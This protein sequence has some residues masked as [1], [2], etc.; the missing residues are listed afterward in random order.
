MNF[1]LLK[2]FSL[3]FPLFPEYILKDIIMSLNNFYITGI[4]VSN[5]KKII[6]K[7]N[8]NISTTTD[9][10]A[11]RSLIISNINNEEIEER[12]IEQKYNSSLIKNI[13][14]NKNGTKIINIKETSFKGEDQSLCEE[15]IYYEKYYYNKKY[16]LFNI[17]KAK[18]L[19]ENREKNSNFDLLTEPEYFYNAV[20]YVE[21]DKWYVTT[22]DY[23]C[24]IN[25]NEN[26]EKTIEYKS[27]VNELLQLYLELKKENSAD[28]LTI[29]NDKLVNV[30]RRKRTFN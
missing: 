19:F 11:Q 30:K 18:T 5:D 7:I 23:E 16:L 22:S 29:F 14:W 8:I 25:G 17:K 12:I 3:F 24:V 27:I 10:N 26:V 15:S 20:Y 6:G 21:D 28:N 1:N 4:K 13:N 9:F 2:N